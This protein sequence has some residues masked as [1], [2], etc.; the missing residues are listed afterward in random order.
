MIRRA[1]EIGGDSEDELLAHALALS[2]QLLDSSAE[3]PRSDSVPES[4]APKAVPVAP[5]R[6][7][8]FDLQTLSPPE[9]VG[10]RRFPRSVRFRHPP[11]LNV[12]DSASPPLPSHPKPS[13]PPH[14]RMRNECQR[15]WVFIWP[16]KP[17]RPLPLIQFANQPMG[18]AVF[19]R[20]LGIFRIFPMQRTESLPCRPIRNRSRRPILIATRAR[21]ARAIFSES[22]DMAP[23]GGSRKLSH[24]GTFV[25][26]DEN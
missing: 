8:R 7:V 24:A 3:G 15:P 6:S 11:M 13:P 19:L 22:P 9:R 18:M 14:R 16:A 4:S 21:E 17:V 25:C 12:S 5:R 20:P 26:F 23:M 10:A 2:V 1:V